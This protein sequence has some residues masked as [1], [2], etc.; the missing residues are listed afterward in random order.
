MTVRFHWSNYVKIISVL[1]VA[2]FIYT[3]ITMFQSSYALNIKLIIAAVLLLTIVVSLML[4]PCSLSIDGNNIVLNRFCYKPIIIPLD[5]I[6]SIKS[7]PDSF[8]PVAVR[9]KLV[10]IWGNGGLFGYWGKFYFPGI[11]QVNMYATELKN[12]VCV[13]ASRKRYVF[14][15]TEHEEFVEEVLRLKRLCEKN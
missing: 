15:C 11:G 7:L 12:F 6:E 13:K 9:M 10:R 5:E 3:L 4:M 8:S 1:A 14:S 2:L